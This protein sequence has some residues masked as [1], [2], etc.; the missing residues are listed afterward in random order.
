[1]LFVLPRLFWGPSSSTALLPAT[2]DV[3]IRLFLAHIISL[4]LVKILRTRIACIRFGR[5]M[6]LACYAW[7]TSIYRSKLA[8]IVYSCLLMGYLLGCRSE[9]LL[10]HSGLLL[11]AREGRVVTDPNAPKVTGMMVQSS[12]VVHR[13]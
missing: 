2:L 1:M 12:Y 5:Y 6:I 9:M 11:R 8:L 3:I 13:S 7:C 10:V 4:S